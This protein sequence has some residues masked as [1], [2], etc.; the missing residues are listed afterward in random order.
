MDS[1]EFRIEIYVAYTE[2]E[3]FIP[4]KHTGP[5]SG[6]I[7]KTAVWCFVTIIDYFQKKIVVTEMLCHRRT[8][9][10]KIGDYFG[11]HQVTKRINKYFSI[12]GNNKRKSR[13]H[14]K[15]D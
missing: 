8:D 13:N 12:A 6:K 9:G 2:L 10:S 11:F 1:F 7:Q 3:A 14:T 15:S 4:L 5:T